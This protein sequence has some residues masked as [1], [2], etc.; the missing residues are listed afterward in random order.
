MLAA[1]AEATASGA[2]VGAVQTAVAAV[3]TGT[4][5]ETMTPAMRA[6]RGGRAAE[7][8]TTTRRWRAASG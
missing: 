8:D 2:T 5:V 7:E 1:E 6:E 3:M 4:A